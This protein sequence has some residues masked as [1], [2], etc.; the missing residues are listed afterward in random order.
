MSLTDNGGQ[1]GTGEV[2]KC[3]IEQ[4]RLKAQLPADNRIPVPNL[5]QTDILN[6]KASS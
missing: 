5:C 1:Q 6:G 3:P 2:A 4:S